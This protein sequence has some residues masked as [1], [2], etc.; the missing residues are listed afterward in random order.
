ME[1]TVRR[2]DLR[3]TEPTAAR[4]PVTAAHGLAVIGVVLFVWCSWSLVAWLASGP[5]AI[6]AARDR[7]SASWPAA[8]VVEGS[9]AALAVVVS[10]SV[11]RECRR[12]RRL[13]TFDVM[14]L[15]AAAPIIW[16]DNAA[17]MFH[18]VFLMTSN[19]V[20]LNSVCGS[21]PLMIDPECG[22]LPD[23]VLFNF[24]N[25]T[26]LF[27]G[28]A[29]AMGWLVRRLRDRRP[30]LSNLHV[31]L[32][33]GL[34]GV[35]LDIL[36]EAVVAVPLRLWAYPGA[37]LDVPALSGTRFP[38]IEVFAAG[39]FFS[40]IAAVRIFRN[41]R[42][43]TLL[44]RGLDRHRPAT[45]RGITFFALFGFLHLAVLLVGTVPLWGF[46]FYARPWP[47]TPAHLVNRICD[48]P[49]VT[50]TAYGPCPGTPGFRTPGRHEP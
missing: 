47:K 33:I 20:N 10:V 48:A 35:V 13:L 9:V 5:H 18:P 14:W 36:L 1:T 32:L 17:N 45:R 31:A 12:A 7:S 8:R 3:A 21:I 11:V 41:D 19:F 2:G 38:I 29:M 15:L 27:L 34:L 25:N 43:E 49:G 24:L 44:E 6:T 39:A 46:G 22:R 16:L 30:G 26:F 37:P 42:G 50:G 40:L 28:I 23:A 4:S